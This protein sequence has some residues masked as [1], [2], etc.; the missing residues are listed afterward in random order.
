MDSRLENPFPY[1]MNKN[2]LGTI[3]DRKQ[4][5]LANKDRR[6]PVETVIIKDR[7]FYQYSLKLQNSKE[8]MVK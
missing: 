8:R 7:I 3:V 2:E 4:I 1:G 6:I 5:L